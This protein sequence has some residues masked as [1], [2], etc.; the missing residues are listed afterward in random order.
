MVRFVIRR[1]GVDG[2]EGHLAEGVAFDNAGC[3]VSWV[4]HGAG[5]TLYPSYE[6]MQAIHAVVDGPTIVVVDNLSEWPPKNDTQEDD[7]L[8][9]RRTLARAQVAFERSKAVPQNS[10]ATWVS[11]S[12]LEGG[13]VSATLSTDDIIDTINIVL[14]SYRNALER[15]W[16]TE[17]IVCDDFET[18][19]HPACSSSLRAW[20]IANEALFEVSPPEVSEET[21]ESGP[22]EDDLSLDERSNDFGS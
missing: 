15:I 21:K 5:V 12:F 16:G 22:A 17:G 10:D 19:S 13:E 2:P 20:N 4:S 3:A 11:T 6:A 14:V 9:L 18:C 7:T 1:A 8:F